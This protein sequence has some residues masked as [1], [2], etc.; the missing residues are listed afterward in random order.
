MSVELTWVPNTE[1]DLD[2]YVVERSLIGTLSAAG[3]F[4]IQ[5]T[6]TVE[7]RVNGESLLTIP[8][9]GVTPGAATSAEVVDALNDVLED[10]DAVAKISIADPLKFIIQSNRQNDRGS[11]RIAGGSAAST[12]GLSTGKRTLGSEWIEIGTPSSASFSDE[13][14]EEKYLYRVSAVNASAEQSDPSDAIEVVSESISYLAVIYGQFMDHNGKAL[15]NAE[16]QYGTPILKRP[17]NDQLQPG[18][19]QRP[20]T[21]VQANF[22]SVYTNDQGYFQIVVPAAM[23]I[24]IKIDAINFDRVKSTPARGESD[25]VTNLSDAWSYQSFELASQLEDFE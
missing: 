10:A 7:V 13:D 1:S 3:P 14:G 12:L 24:R 23:A 19:R 25:D 22:Q 9:T 17:S 2:Y 11:L 4:N 15:K 5:P 18:Y 6:D 20:S 8:M 16:V 21:G